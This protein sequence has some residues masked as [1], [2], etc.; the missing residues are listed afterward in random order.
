[1]LAA[2]FLCGCSAH[3]QNVG[4]GIPTSSPV[5]AAGQPGAIPLD[6]GQRRELDEILAAAPATERPLLRYAFPTD[7]A[8]RRA[9]AVY[10][11][12]GLPPDGHRRGRPHEYVLFRMLNGPMRGEHYDPVEN[13]VVPPIP[14]PTLRDNT[15]G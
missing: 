11:G 1:M 13:V 8:G 15:G 5:S 12:E 7:D 3:V 2:A 9:L 4:P 6:G 14:A 10:D